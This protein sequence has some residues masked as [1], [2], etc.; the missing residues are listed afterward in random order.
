MTSADLSEVFRT[1]WPRIV[2]VILK[3]FG[4]L[5]LAED[6][7]QEAFIAAG[8]AW[9]NSGV[10]DSPGAWLL[11]TARRKAIDHLRRSNNYAQKL[12]L[13]EAQARSASHGGSAD[14][15][16]DDQ[17]ALFLGCCHPALNRDAQVALTLRAV[18]GLSTAQIASAFLVEEAT[19]GKRLTRARRKI[20]DANIPFSVPDRELLR[21]RLEQVQQVI[22]LIFTEG[23][24]SAT[25]AQL[26]R[27]D[28][29]DEAIWLSELVAK[30]VPDDSETLALAAL[31]RL[32]D[33]RRKTRTDADGVPVLLQDQDRLKWDVKQIDEGL[34]YLGRAQQ[35][36]HPGPLL[37]Q[38]AVAAIH[39]TASHFDQ[40]DWPKIVSLY[41]Q[42]IALGSTPILRLNRAAALAYA[43]GPEVALTEI[44][45]LAD[46]LDGYVFFHS[47]RAE[48][49]RRLGLVS[50]A[51]SAYDRALECNPGEGQQRFLKASRARLFAT[52]N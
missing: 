40:T 52:F 17:L 44:D 20:R 28:L 22:Y 8:V 32:T 13:L 48:L 24:S 2:A 41:D 23:H 18:A 31:I 4:D 10:P 11:T 5:Q 12:P 43:V 26:V 42:Q 36:P 19:M 38:A 3:N 49:L 39:C 1:E 21:N 37:F 16:I 50:L 27:G 6:C 51:I 34:G 9:P 14:G 7:A 30:L 25:D 15:L 47:A 29:C 46:D 33:A 35:S 45:Q